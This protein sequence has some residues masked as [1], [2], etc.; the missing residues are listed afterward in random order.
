VHAPYYDMVEAASYFLLGVAHSYI[1]MKDDPTKRYYETHA[2][3]YF[4]PEA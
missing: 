2:D 3:E 1:T 4:Q